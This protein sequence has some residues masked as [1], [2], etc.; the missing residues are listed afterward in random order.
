MTKQLNL[1]PDDI[2][3][4]AAECFRVRAHPIRLR[5][6]DMLMQGEFAVHDI[7][8]TCKTSANQSCEHLR[9][10]RS[11]K[12]LTSQRR[13]K[14]VYYSINTPQLPGMLACIKKNCTL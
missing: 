8:D 13:G 5:M 9:L 10:M 4:R 3:E 7:A 11:H 14:T 12:L 1:I 6:V 2:L